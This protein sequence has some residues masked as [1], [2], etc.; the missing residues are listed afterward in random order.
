VLLL[1][2]L[3]D[4]NTGA[5]ILALQSNKFTRLQAMHASSFY[6]GSVFAAGTQSGTVCFIDSRIGDVV[7]EWRAQQGPVRSLVVSSYNR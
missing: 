3:W 5:N 2:Q 4:G 1:E 6:G 7:L